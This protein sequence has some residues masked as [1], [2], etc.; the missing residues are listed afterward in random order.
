MK[1]LSSRV[2]LAALLVFASLLL[3]SVVYFQSSPPGPGT[4]D[5]LKIIEAAT[6]YRDQLQAQGLE[7][8]ESVTLNA[9]I[10]EG[11]LQAADARDFEGM[12]VEISLRAPETP[13]AR[14]ISV[15]MADGTRF[16]ALQDGS[17]QRLNR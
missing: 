5:Y 12:E 7:I 6:V 15:K 9:L 1:P 4:H 13:G 11:H 3:I 14:L 8:P 10:K 16:A 17:V 2:A